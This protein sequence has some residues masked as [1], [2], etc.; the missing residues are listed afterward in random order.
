MFRFF[1]HITSL[2][3]P[4]SNHQNRSKLSTFTSPTP[5]FFSIAL[6]KQQRRSVQQQHTMEQDRAAN[7]PNTPNG[8]FQNHHNDQKELNEHFLLNENNV[9]SRKIL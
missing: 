3:Y 1:F 7:R 2:H 5:N 6:R 9:D 8:S 4:G